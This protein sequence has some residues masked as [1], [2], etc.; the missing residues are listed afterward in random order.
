MLGFEINDAEEE[1]LETNEI[2]LEV[3]SFVILK[4]TQVESPF[5]FYGI[6]PYGPQDANKLSEDYPQFEELHQI[7][8]WLK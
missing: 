2:S 1:L 3:N 7:Q 5:S 4:V 8:T 6:L